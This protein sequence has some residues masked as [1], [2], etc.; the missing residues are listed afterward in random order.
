MVRSLRQTSFEQEGMEVVE[1]KGHGHLD[2]VCDVIMK[3]ISVKLSKE[4]LNRFGMIMHHD[5]D[6]SLLVAGVTET[7]FDGGAV[8]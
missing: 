5:V 7:R 2:H 3:R 4:H 6:K 8:K 1:R